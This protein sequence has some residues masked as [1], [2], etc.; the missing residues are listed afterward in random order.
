M[1]IDLLLKNAYV[2]NVYFKKFIVG[3]IAISGDKFLYI[4]I[5]KP[6][7]IPK[8]VID[9][10]GRYIIPGLVDCHMHIESTMCAPRTF[11]NWVVK[12][13]VT[14]LIAEPHEIANVFGLEGITAMAQSMKDG[15]ADI[16]IA[17]PSSVPSTNACLETTGAEIGSDSVAAMLHM[18]KVICLGEVMN[19]HD[20]IA[21][22]D[23]KTSRLVRQVKEN[24]PKFPLEGHLPRFLDWD[25]AQILYNGVNSDH[26]DQTL[27]TIRQRIAGGCFLQLQEKTIKPEFI[28]YLVEHNLF[29]HFAIVTDDTMPDSFMKRGHLNY[30]VKKAMKAGLTPEQAIYAATY[31]PA[32]RMG[33]SDK[34]SIAPGK[35]ADFVVLDDPR[36]FHVLAT[37][38]SGR[39]VYR[40]N[41][42][43]E[44][45]ERDTSFPSHF[46]HS[47]H[48]TPRTEDNFTLHVEQETGSVCCRILCV[49]NKTTFVQ[50]ETAVLPVKNHEICWED[51]PYN[52]AV[53][54]ERHGKNGG[55]GYALVG[56]AAMKKGA[57]ATTYAHDHHNLLV[58]GQTKADMMLAANT[59]IENQGG[60]AAAINN[61]VT[62][63]AALPIAGILSDQPLDVLG[64]QIQGVTQSL[65]EWGYDHPNI[66]MSLSTLSLPVSPD[67]KVTDKGIIDVSKQ[68]ILPM[69]L[70]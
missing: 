58:I 13:G 14:T 59:V 3:N 61:T 44:P 51:S 30:L 39:E 24:A 35:I 6:P 32:R 46:Y 2:F 29:E 31:T 23:T 33:L 41:A 60:Y 62:A 57:A 20:I 36:Q 68:K 17:I 45:E 5:K 19:G 69:I 48:V 4:G 37:Y 49:S 42:V 47:V 12:N 56:G 52:L 18:D 11:S 15:P 21:G 67:I 38:C 66:I 16:Y 53:V 65:Q 70:D 25:L 9:L 1:Q 10:S 8:K 22:P 40:R 50:E 26:T 34:G 7:V 63:F 64:K 27:E 55:C 54:F 43:Q 28:Q